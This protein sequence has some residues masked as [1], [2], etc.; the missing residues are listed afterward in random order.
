MTSSVGEIMK[1][2]IWIFSTIA[3][4]ILSVGLFVMSM[5]VQSQNS[6]YKSAYELNNQELVCKTHE[7]KINQLTAELEQTKGA[8]SSSKLNKIDR[9]NNDVS[10][11]LETYYTID[12]DHPAGQR[13]AKLK[14][15]LSKDMA[16]YLK[17]TA[18]QSV[19]YMQS[20]EIKDKYYSKV[21]NTEAKLLY[22]C[23]TVLQSDDLGKLKESHIFQIK[24]EYDTKTKTWRIVYLGIASGADFQEFMAQ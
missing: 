23:N 13:Y 17:R 18:S 21:S 14:N 11:A 24:A 15:Y 1:K 22:F 2:H 5:I 3:L 4:A 9:V 7:D 12:K 19:S 20:I 10:Y 6:S 8:L 16:A